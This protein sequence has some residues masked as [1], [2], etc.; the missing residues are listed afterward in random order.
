MTKKNKLTFTSTNPDP[1]T[2][3]FAA[4]KIREAHM[5]ELSNAL[6]KAA[7]AVL[8]G[9]TTKIRTKGVTIEV[10]ARP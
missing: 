2:L 8:E 9:R 4:R 6:S 1:D 5:N 7:K 10:K 3:D